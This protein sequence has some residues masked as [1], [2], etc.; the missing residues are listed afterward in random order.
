DKRL[1]MDRYVIRRLVS[2]RDETIDIDENQY[3]TALNITQKSWTVDRGR[4][5]RKLPPDEPEGVDIRRIRPKSNGLVLIYP[6]EPEGK[7]EKGKKGL[8]IVGFA[9]SFP[10][11][12]DD[13][14]VRYVVNNV[15]YEQE[16]GLGY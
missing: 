4:S 13:K 3:A 5:T 6:L 15:Y 12:R 16:Y 9:I 2:G 8:P 7:S 14:K 10:G 1:S 11:N